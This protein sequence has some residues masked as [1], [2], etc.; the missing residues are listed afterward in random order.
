ME[1]MARRAKITAIISEIDSV[2][3]VREMGRRLIVA[4]FSG[5]HQTVFKDYLALGIQSK[6]TRAVRTELQRK[7]PTLPY[8]AEQVDKTRSQ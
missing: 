6:R 3:P 1:I 4:G 7:Q 8:M 2:P 5:N